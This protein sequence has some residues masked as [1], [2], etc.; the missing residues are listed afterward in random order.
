MSA[1]PV[2]GARPLQPSPDGRGA[3]ADARGRAGR[4]RG[5]RGHRGSRRPST[6]PSRSEPDV[7]VVEEGGAVDAA[8]VVRR[9]NCPVVLDVDITTTRAWTLR[10]ESLSTPPGRLPGRH[11]RGRRPLRQRRRPAP[12]RIAARQPAAA[13]GL[14]CRPTWATTIAPVRPTAPALRSPHDPDSAPPRPA[15]HRR[16]RAGRRRPGRGPR[17]LRG[18]A[19]DGDAGLR[20]RRPG[21]GHAHRG[22]VHRGHGRPD[23]GGAPSGS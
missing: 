3:G 10:R 5:R 14:G 22:R 1:D 18:A 17:G 8:D 13:S 12:S 7:I 11:P 4:H 2:R 16:R 9:S 19:R 23:D 21:A 20:P 15:A 6:R